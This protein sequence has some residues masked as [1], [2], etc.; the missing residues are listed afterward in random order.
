RGR[1]GLATEIDLDDTAAGIRRG[2]HLH[3]IAD[4]ARGRLGEIEIEI[5]AVDDA[6]AAKGREAL[7][8]LLADQ[9]KLRIGRVAQ[10]QHTELDTVEARRTLAH[11]LV[12]GPHGAR[13]RIALAPGGGD[14]NEL[15]G[16]GERRKI[17]IRHINDGWLEA[18]LARRLGNVA[19]ELFR[20]SGLARIHNGQ[21][22]RRPRRRRRLQRRV[23]AARG[24]VEARQESGEPG[25]LDRRR[26][27]DHAIEEIDLLLGERRGLRNRLHFYSHF[28]AARPAPPYCRRQI[29]AGYR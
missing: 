29:D 9:A 15:L 13:R 14:E 24:G 23:R 25:P 17:E 22:L 5:D 12:V 18:V 8:D 11:Q 16:G 28:P 27:A 19:G 10:R 20:I 1:G 2:Q 7:V 3:R 26:G 21:R 6:L 4:P